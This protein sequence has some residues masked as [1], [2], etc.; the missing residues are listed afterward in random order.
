MEYHIPERFDD[1]RPAVEYSHVDYGASITEHPL[2]SQVPSGSP[3]DEPAVV[4]DPYGLQSLMRPDDGPKE[5]GDYLYTD[6]PQLALHIVSF[7]DA[8]LV[9]LTWPHTLWD[10]MGRRELLL[11]WTA[12]LAGREDDVAPAYEPDEHPLRG[13]A[14]EPREEYKLLGMRLSLPQ[15]LVFGFRYWLEGFWYSAEKSRVVCLPA[16]FMARLRAESA[17]EAKAADPEGNGFL[18]DGDLISAWCARQMAEHTPLGAGQ[19]LCVTNAMGWRALLQPDVLEKGKAYLGNATCLSYAHV[20]AGDIVSRP[21]GYTAS[22][23][24]RSLREQATRPQLEAVA[25]LLAETY[26][27]TGNPPVFGNAGM[28]LMVVS[29]W[30]KGRFFDMDFSPAVVGGAGEGGVRPVYIQPCVFNKGFST[31]NA[32]QVSGKDGAGN[33]WLSATLRSE[34]WDAIERSLST[35]ARG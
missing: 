13:F 32:F 6:R 26:Q 15:L 5:I 35:T 29:N 18:S 12:V 10:A 4:L 27:A 8:T 24:R 7:T 11:A 22:A 31:R 1:S 34:V 25:H 9:N 2:G 21:L 19:T 33:Y 17:A 20:K 14:D 3:S 28:K 16:A 23:V 30:S